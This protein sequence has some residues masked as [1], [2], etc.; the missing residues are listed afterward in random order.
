MAS[1]SC[2]QLGGGDSVGGGDNA[3]W[4]S[5]WTEFAVTREVGG[6]NWNDT[7]NRGNRN[8]HHRLANPATSQIQ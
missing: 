3:A 8:W 4:L 7:F 5:V 6:P 2:L 1:V